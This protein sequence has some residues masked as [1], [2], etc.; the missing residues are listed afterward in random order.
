[1]KIVFF[2]T[3]EFATS[4]LKALHEADNHEVLAVVTQPDKRAGR[5]K[6]IAI[7]NV[8]EYALKYDI[9]IF[10]PEKIKSKQ[11]SAEIAELGA[12][13]FVTAAYG[14][15]FGKNMLELPEFGC[16]NVHASLLPKY[17]GASPIQQTILNG[18][19][20]AG[21]T[22]M[23]MDIGMDTGDILLQE[24]VPVL[25]SDTSWHLHGRLCQIAPGALLKALDLI[26][27]G[28][29]TRTPQKN[30]KITPSYAPII[31]KQMGRID[32]E[33]E[34]GQISLHVKAYNPFPGAF[35]T[36]EGEIIKI[37][38][39]MAIIDYHICTIGCEPGEILIANP[40]Y[41]LIV[42]CGNGDYI[43]HPLCGFVTPFVSV[44]Q[45]QPQNGKIM[46]AKEY[47]RGRRLEIGNV[48]K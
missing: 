1:M 48:F 47:L 17:R 29:I 22:I 3:P 35:T 8:K 34:S 40:K 2:G 18:D 13:I 10:Q 16:I 26:E 44:L 37:W 20:T 23:Q 36:Y 46:E 31:T 9:P 5:G 43:D 14:Q 6:K 24:E 11:F 32:W 30:I 21:V 12:D 7:S 38:D 25:S 45:M 19:S 33:Q 4:C 28:K 39:V 42:A 27:K 15:I 41:G